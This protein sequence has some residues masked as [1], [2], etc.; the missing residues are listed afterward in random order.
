MIYVDIVVFEDLII[1]YIILLSTGLLLNRISNLKKIF[2]SSV[3][4]TIPLIFLFINISRLLLNIINL[5]FLIIMAIISF[6]YKNIIYTFKNI[7][8][9]YLTSI[10]LA[11]SIYLI[12]T[13]YLPKINSYI[14]KIFIYILI[15]ILSTYIYTK[16]LK[17]LKNNNSNYYKVDIYLKDKPKITLMS[18]LDT[19]NKLKDPYNNKPIILISKNKIDYHNQKIILVPYNTIDNNGLLECFSP[20]KIYI[21]KIGYRKRLLIGLIDNVN[22]ENADCIMNESLLER[23]KI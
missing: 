4:G 2:L 15:S 9:M 17:K 23:I 22:I 20:E 11:G 5:I 1:N 19:G 3:I 8:Y 16:Y 7:I 12:N 6:N 13:N 21:K 18:F 14:L 10:F